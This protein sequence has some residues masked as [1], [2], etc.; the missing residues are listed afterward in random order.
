MTSGQVYSSVIANERRGD[1]LGGTIQVI[2]HVTNEIKA[3]VATV[4]KETGAQVVI[5]EV[6]GVTG[7]IENLPFLEAIRQLHRE[8]GPGNALY[9]HVTFVP[10]LG[11]TGELKTKP[12]QQSVRELRS[13]GIQ[14]DAIVCRSDYELPDDIREKIALFCDVEP[15]AVVPLPTVDTIYQVPLTLEAAGL[16]EYVVEKLGLS[17]ATQPDWTEW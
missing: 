6:G 7:D 3:R 10:Y 8:I 17:A 16:G 2:P 9:V 4:T 15:R 1:F 5:A 12:T 13:I 11:A 14:P